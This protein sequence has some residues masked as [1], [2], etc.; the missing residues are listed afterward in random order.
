MPGQSVAQRPL[1]ATDE[2]AIAQTMAGP[3]ANTKL[4]IT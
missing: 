1:A 3:T 2:R 4:D